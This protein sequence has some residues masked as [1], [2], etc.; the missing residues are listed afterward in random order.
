[1]Q[2]SWVQVPFITHMPTLNQLI[3]K[4]R[5]KRVSGANSPRKPQFKGIVE[6]V[7]TR[8]PKKPNSAQRKVAK[9]KIKGMRSVEAY[10]MG[11]GHNL[12]EHGVVLVRGG[13]VGDLPGV[14]YKLVRGK[15]DLEGVRGRK[16][17]RSK[18][19][20]KKDVS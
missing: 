9:V 3:K 11:E 7:F 16:T 10:I 19:G 13:R 14:N 15:F 20:R 18:Y 1:M 8:K 2:R 4:A 5:L 6:R 17:S 12:Q